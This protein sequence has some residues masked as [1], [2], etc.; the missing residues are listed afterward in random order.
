[1]SRFDRQISLKNFGEEGQKRLKNA[2]ILVVGVGGLGCP[3]LL[4]LAAAGIGKIGLVDGD[5]VSL[6]NLNRQLIFGENDIGKSKVIV[7]KNY[8]DE[9]YKDI[10]IEIF[11]FF[12]NP[13]NIVPII[14]KYELVID[15]TDNFSSRY[16]LNDACVLLQKPLIMGAIYQNEGQIAVLNLPT[17]NGFSCNYRDLY[18]QAPQ[19]NEVPNCNEIGV[20]GV[21]TAII[22]TMQAAEAIKFL[23]KMTNTQANRLYFYHFLENSLFD[24]EIMPNPLSKKFIP[25]NIEI[26]QNKDYSLSC[27][28]SKLI[29]WRKAVELYEKN[30][31]KAL[32]LDVR[33]HHEKP[34]ITDFFVL[35]IPLQRLE[36]NWIKLCAYQIVFIFC[37]AG[38]RSL[39]AVE[40]LEKKF[41]QKTFFSIEHGITDFDSSLANFL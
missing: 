8:F 41:P 31:Q 34:K 19:A 12:I 36:K 39:K 32:F 29:S 20:L 2:K 14:Q 27:S 16:L 18:P 3:A 30:P 23:A 26:L 15:A 24:I 5:T 17:E 25:E 33:N 22:G 6:S 35:E 7:A 1:M 10:E 4:S 11:N 28:A 40:F 37:Q 13:Q 38:T 21:L 9:K